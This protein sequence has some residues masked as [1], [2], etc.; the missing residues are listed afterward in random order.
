L[1]FF[2]PDAG[3]ANPEAAVDP[4]ATWANDREHCKETKTPVVAIAARTTQARFMVSF[5]KE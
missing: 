2:L 3:L 5:L 1:L 4:D